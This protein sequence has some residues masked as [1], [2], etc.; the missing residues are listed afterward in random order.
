MRR[1]KCLLLILFTVGSI[2]MSQAQITF[3]KGNFDEAVKKAREENKNLFIDFYTA[4]CAPCK[5]MAQKVFVLPELGGYFN[6]KFISC[7]LNAEAKENA[8]LVKKYKVDAFPLMLFLNPKG[9]VLRTARGAQQPAA[10][11]LEARIAA[12]DALSFE[13]LYDKAKKEKKNE[14]LQQELLFRAPAF[15]STQTGYNRE[16]W[17]VRVELLF[18]DYLKNRKLENMI[19][20]EDLF[21]IS[22][23]HPEM[24][25]NDPIFDF[26]VKH[27]D[28][29]VEKVGKNDI[30]DF[31]IGM[32]NSYIL[33]FCRNGKLEYKKHL[34]RVNGDLKPIYAGIPFGTLSAYEAISLLADGYYALFRKDSKIFF[35]KMDQYF[36]GVGNVLT[37]ND[38]TQP[39][40]DIYSIYQGR[41][42]EEANLKM[43]EWLGKVLEKDMDP[44]LRTRLLCMLGDCFSGTG[45]RDKAKQSFNQA[46]IVSTEIEDKG[47]MVQ[48]QKMIQER[49]ST[50]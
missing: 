6:K 30:Q 42:P 3:F 12:G 26:L 49:L 39:I 48:L 20:A 46:F 45:N 29:Y 38:Y 32:Y 50:L 40:E 43:I 23:Y 18:H 22:M 27:Y 9:E 1:L 21:I 2:G 34:E 47:V 41:L 7:Q 33:T 37:I 11:L 19:N 17:S 4:W 36:N 15:M 44:R 28:E 8:E 5:L 31:L 14:T 35:E 25:D 10:L 16:K 13:K 24:E